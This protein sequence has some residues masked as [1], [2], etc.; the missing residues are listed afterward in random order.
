MLVV[1]NIWV[2]S[3]SIGDT[4]FNLLFEERERI[5]ILVVS[6]RSEEESRI[7]STYCKPLLNLTFKYSQEDTR[8]ELHEI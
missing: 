6:P 2:I 4:H 5:Y 1:L 7:S 8:L 3:E